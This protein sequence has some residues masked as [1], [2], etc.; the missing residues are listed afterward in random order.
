MTLLQLKNKENGVLLGGQATRRSSPRLME[1]GS[2][3]LPAH[4]TDGHAFQGLPQG[5]LRVKQASHGMAL[6]LPSCCFRLG[7]RDD[8]LLN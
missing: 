4:G 2:T 6:A 1:P 8:G 7:L 3:A 5:L